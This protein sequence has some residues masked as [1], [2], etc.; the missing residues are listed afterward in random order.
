MAFTA[1]CW[2]EVKKGLDHILFCLN[3][4]LSIFGVGLKK[5]EGTFYMNK[6]AY[7]KQKASW[8]YEERNA[9][10]LFNVLGPKRYYKKL[11]PCVCC[12]TSE[13][14]LLKKDHIN[15]SGLFKYTQI[16]KRKPKLIRAKM[17][18]A[19]QSF[20][21]ARIK[22]K[23]I[24]KILEYSKIKKLNYITKI[25]KRKKKRETGIL[26]FK[27]RKYVVIGVK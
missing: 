4:R 14:P 19:F 8:K 17:T 23:N 3:G 24:L 25:R 2:Q 27:S 9:T 11:Y 12:Y 5:K 6:Y 20:Y 21:H 22:K 16:K 18:V 13:S 26:K 15:H 7:F 1:N 10:F